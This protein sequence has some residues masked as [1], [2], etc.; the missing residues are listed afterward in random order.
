MISI[1]LVGNPC[2]FSKSVKAHVGL[3]VV[4]ARLLGRWNPEQPSEAVR[5][6]RGGAPATR[7]EPRAKT[8][9][10]PPETGAPVSGGGDAQDQR[11][12]S[13]RSPRNPSASSGRRPTATGAT[14][15]VPTRERR[16]PDRG[17]RRGR[18]PRASATP[19]A[20]RRG[21]GRR[22]AK[23]R[24]LRSLRDA[25]PRVEGPSLVFANSSICQRASRLNPPP[26][27][28]GR[29][30]GPSWKFVGRCWNAG[31]QLYLD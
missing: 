3:L 8:G 11:K 31:S 22:R 5:E 17:T 2:N 18:G 19:A 14:R 15:D 20:G 12:N 16:H 30:W 21:G 28:S 27:S 23:Q 1:G 6:T 10:F 9:P 29:G 24:R 7:E 13:K 4:T 25:P 26:L